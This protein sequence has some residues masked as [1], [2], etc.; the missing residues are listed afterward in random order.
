M[1]LKGSDDAT[2]QAGEYKR[3]RACPRRDHRVRCPGSVKDELFRT[4]QNLHAA[5][6]LK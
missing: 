4:W 3:G 5:Q 6:T 1:R 2:K